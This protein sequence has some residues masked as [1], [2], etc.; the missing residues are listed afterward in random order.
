M[1]FFFKSSFE[2]NIANISQLI[3]YYKIDTKR[4]VRSIYHYVYLKLTML[5]ALSVYATNP[6]THNV[7]KSSITLIMR[8]TSF[9]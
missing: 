5:A 9:K 1:C 4:V 7:T 3:Y 8:P 6:Q 2:A